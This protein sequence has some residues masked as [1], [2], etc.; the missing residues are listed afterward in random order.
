MLTVALWNALKKP[1]K[2]HP[3]FYRAMRLRKLGVG[4]VSFFVRPTRTAVERLRREAANSF[5]TRLILFFA[6]LPLAAFSIFAILF[7]GIPILMYGGPVLLPLIS[8]AH[9]LTWAVG[10]GSLISTERERKTYDLLCVTPFGP[11]PTVWA[12][13]SGYAHFDK[14]LRNVNQIRAWQLAIIWVIV[15][16]I[17]SMAMLQ[18]GQMG[19]YFTLLPVFIA[20]LAAFTAILY[21]DQYQ[22]IIVGVLVALIIPTLGRAMQETRIWIT[23]IFILLQFIVY[24]ITLLISLGLLPVIYDILNLDNLLT[25]YGT[26]ALMVV[27]FFLLHEAVIRWLWHELKTRIGLEAD[28][29]REVQWS[30]TKIDS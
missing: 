13:A 21:I 14:T 26:P 3:V 19:Y 8:N 6:A 17:G 10:I 1:F 5:L 24:L 23:S 11:L 20:Y 18:F 2:Q 12:I 29:M 9:G 16:F 7:A 22:S 4:E 15:P 28:T 27:I 30:I 25:D